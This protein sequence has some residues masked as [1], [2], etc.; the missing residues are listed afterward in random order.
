MGER[1]GIRLFACARLLPFVKIVYRHKAAPSFKR[2]AESRLALDPLGLGVDIREPDFDVLCPVGHETPAQ[3]IQAAFAGLAIV[4][5]HGQQISRRGVPSR[6]KVGRR[7]L[8]WYREDELYL[9][10]IGG[11]ADAATHV[12]NIASS[13][14]TPKPL[15]SMRRAWQSCVER[16]R[17][18]TC[19]AI[20]AR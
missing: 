19:P 4:A 1:D 20:R 17:N 6:R 5:D 7:P 16:M 15:D 10:H 3:K 13:R 9:T 18:T 2:F 12:E 8:G 11:E 14:C